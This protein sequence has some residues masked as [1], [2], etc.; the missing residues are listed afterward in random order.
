[1]EHSNVIEQYLRFNGNAPIYVNG[2][3]INAGIMGEHEGY[4][5]VDVGKNDLSYSEKRASKGKA[6]ILVN[7]VTIFDVDLVCSNSPETILINFPKD[8]KLTKSRDRVICGANEREF[9]KEMLSVLSKDAKNI[10]I[11][12]A[13]YPV[14]RELQ[15]NNNDRGDNLEHF[16]INTIKGLVTSSHIRVLPDVPYM[17]QV[18]LQER[19]VLIRPELFRQLKNY[20]PILQEFNGHSGGY[21]VFVAEFMSDDIVFVHDNMVVILNSKYIPHNVEEVAALEMLMGFDDVN[22]QFTGADV[23][24]GSNSKIIGE[25]IGSEKNTSM[26]NN[27]KKWA[28]NFPGIVSFPLVI[29]MKVVEGIGLF[30]SKIPYLD[31]FMPR[32]ANIGPYKGRDYTFFRHMLSSVESRILPNDDMSK[33]PAYVKALEERIKKDVLGKGKKRVD[34]WKD[35]LKRYNIE[36]FDFAKTVENILDLTRKRSESMREG[37]SRVGESGE[38][39]LGSEEYKGMDKLMDDPVFMADV[40][41]LEFINK[42]SM[43]LLAFFSSDKEM[44]NCFDQMV[45]GLRA[46]GMGYGECLALFEGIVKNSSRNQRMNS[47]DVLVRMKGIV[48]CIDRL[49]NVNFADGEEMETFLSKLATRRWLA[50]ITYPKFDRNSHTYL[51]FDAKN[52]SPMTWD[53][54]NFY[55]GNDLDDIDSPSGSYRESLVRGI[56]LLT[57]ILAGDKFDQ[58]YKDKYFDILGKKFLSA[59]R[60]EIAPGELAQFVMYF[61][62]IVSV[63]E[64]KDERFLDVLEKELTKLIRLCKNTIDSD[65]RS[66]YPRVSDIAVKGHSLD[67]VST[68][69]DAGDAKYLFD[70]LQVFSDTVRFKDVD[71]SL[72]LSL[73]KTIMARHIGRSEGFQEWSYTYSSTDKEGEIRI[74]K[75]AQDEYEYI[76]NVLCK[77]TDHGVTSSKDVHR[78]ARPYVF[79]LDSGTDILKKDV[80]PDSARIGGELNTPYSLKLSTLVALYLGGAMKDKN[81]M[82]KDKTAMELLDM[83]RSG[84][85]TAGLITEVSRE[86]AKN[87]IIESINYESSDEYIFIREIIQNVLDA[88]GKELDVSAINGRDWCQLGFTDNVGMSIERVVKFLLIPDSTTKLEDKEARGKFGQGFFT[89][90]K[91]ARMVRVKTSDGTGKLVIV[92]M[93]PVRKGELIVD[94]DI[95]VEIKDDASFKGTN[96]EWLRDSDI[97]QLE[98][99][100]VRSK[101]LTYGCLIDDAE[102]K[103]NWTVNNTTAVINKNKELMGQIET[104]YGKVGLY[105]SGDKENVVTH[106]GLYVR[107]IDKYFWDTIPVHIREQLSDYGIIIDLPAGVELISDRSDV[108]NKEEILSKLQ[109]HLAKLS[110]IAILDLFASNKVKLGFMPYDFMKDGRNWIIPNSVKDDAAALKNGQ[111]INVAPY[112]ASG[113]LFGQLIASIPFISLKGKDEHFSLVYV[114]EGIENGSI[115]LDD[116]VN[117]NIVECITT[118]MKRKAQSRRQAEERREKGYKEFYDITLPIE[119]R[120]DDADVYWAFSEFMKEVSVM[121][122]AGQRENL[123]SA[124][125]M[126]YGS[127]GNDKA[128]AFQNSSAMGWNIYSNMELFDQFSKYL[129]DEI[130]P[131]QAIYTIRDMFSTQLHE[132]AHMLENTGETTHNDEFFARQ[133]ALTKSFLMSIGEISK[134]AE[135][136][137]HEYKGTVIDV[138]SFANYLL[139]YRDKGVSPVTLRDFPAKDIRSPKQMSVLTLT[140]TYAQDHAEELLKLHHLIEGQKWTTDQ[141]LA[142]MWKQGEYGSS[143]DRPF[144][145]KWEHSFVATS[146]DGKPIGVL[147]AY[148]RPANEM[149]GVDGAALY[150]H[151]IAVDP[152]YQGSG[153]GK[154]LMLELAEQLKLRGLQYLTASRGETRIALQTG[155][156]NLAAQKFYFNLGFEEV[157]RKYYPASG[158]GEA[159]S[160]LVLSASCEDVIKNIIGA[161]ASVAVNNMDAFKLTHPWKDFPDQNGRY[162]ADMI[163]DHLSDRVY[164]ARQIQALFPGVAIRPADLVSVSVE[165]GSHRSGSYK[166]YNIVNV[167]AGDKQYRFGILAG[168]LFKNEY[169]EKKLFAD[170]GIGPRVG[171]MGDNEIFKRLNKLE[172]G[173]VAVQHVEG[174]TVSE[175]IDRGDWKEASDIYAEILRKFNTIGFF[176]LDIFNNGDNVIKGNDGNLYIIDHCV[177]EDKTDNLKYP[178]HVLFALMLQANSRGETEV[179]D[180]LDH[181][182]I[183]EIVQMWY[184]DFYMDKPDS[185][186]EDEIDKILLAAGDFSYLAQNPRDVIKTGI[187]G[188]LAESL[189]KT[190]FTDTKGYEAGFAPLKDARFIAGS[191]AMGVV[192]AATSLLSGSL[193]VGIAF[194]IAAAAI[195]VS[196][197]SYFT[198]SESG[199]RSSGNEGMSRR[200][201]LTAA[202]IGIISLSPVIAET[203]N[204][205][206]KQNNAGME[207]PDIVMSDEQIRDLVATLK[208]M[209]FEID[210]EMVRS[211]IRNSNKE[212]NKTMVKE[213][214]EGMRADANIPWNRDDVYPVLFVDGLK[215]EG[216]AM[217]ITDIPLIIV[218]AEN[219]PKDKKQREAWLGEKIAHE[220]T[221]IANRELVELGAMTRL[222]D[223]AAAYRVTAA[224]VEKYEPL[225]KEG[226]ITQRMVSSAFDVI[227]SPSGQAKLKE[228]VNIP[229]DR[230]YYDNIKILG[231]YVGIRI[232]QDAPEGS[233]VKKVVWVDVSEGEIKGIDLD[234]KMELSSAGK[235]LTSVVLAASLLPGSNREQAD[236]ISLNVYKLILKRGLEKHVGALRREGVIDKG[237]LDVFERAL[238]DMFDKDLK[239]KDVVTWHDYTHAANMALRA[240]EAMENVLKENPGMSANALLLT[241][242]AAMYHDVGYYSAD[243]FSGA[244]KFGHEDR[245]MAYVRDHERDLGI[246]SRDAARINLMISATKVEMGS[247]FRDLDPLVNKIS[248]GKASADEIARV[249]TL[250]GQNGFSVDTLGLDLS[251]HRDVEYLL[252]LIYGGEILATLDVYDTRPDVAE[253]IDDLHNEFNF[254]RDTINQKLADEKDSNV[255]A[256]LEML[257]STLEMSKDHLDAIGKTREFYKKYADD[258]VAG[259]GVWGKYIKGEIIDDFDAKRA[260]IYAIGEAAANPDLASSAQYADRHLSRADLEF[261]SRF[262]VMVELERKGMPNFGSLRDIIPRAPPIL[263]LETIIDVFNGIWN[264]YIYANVPSDELAAVGRFKADTIRHSILTAEL[265]GL[266]IR[267]MEKDGQVFSDQDVRDIMIAAIFHDIGK[268]ITAREMASNRIFAKEE[269]PAIVHKHVD[270]LHGNPDKGDYKKFRDVLASYGI[271]I[272]GSSI[273]AIQGMMGEHYV[274]AMPGQNE[275]HRTVEMG[276]LLYMCDDLLGRFDGAREHKKPLEGFSSVVNMAYDRVQKVKTDAELSRDKFYIACT[277]ALSEI[278]PADMMEA[279]DVDKKTFTGLLYEN[280]FLSFRPLVT[281]SSWAGI[282][283]DKVAQA[284][285]KQGLERKIITMYAEHDPSTSKSIIGYKGE[286]YLLEVI[287]EVLEL[288]VFAPDR[289]YVV[290]GLNEEF[291]IPGIRAKDIARSIFALAD[292]SD[293]A[294]KEFV[295]AVAELA[296]LNEIDFVKEFKQKLPKD[297]SDKPYLDLASGPNI[298]YFSNDL[299]ASRKYYFVDRSYYV[300]TFLER[301]MELTGHNNVEI[302]QKDILDL[303]FGDESL[304]T[305][306]VKNLLLYAKVPDTYWDKAAKWITP[307]GQ[308]TVQADPTFK[309]RKDCAEMVRVLYEK[310]VVKDGW[311]FNVILGVEAQQPFDSTLDTVT[312]VKP[313]SGQ[314]LTSNKNLDEYLAS[315]GQKIA[316]KKVEEPAKPI[317]P[318]SREEAYWH[319]SMVSFDKFDENRIGFGTGANQEGWGFSVTPGKENAKEYASGAAGKLQPGQKPISIKI[320]INGQ[321]VNSFAGHEKYYAKRLFNIISA[322]G[323]VEDAREA[324]LSEVREAGD[325]EMEKFIANA[326]ITVNIERYLYRIDV[327]EDPVWLELNGK[328]DKSVWTMI[329]A[330][331]SKE[332]VSFGKYFNIVDGEPQVNMGREIYAALINILGSDKE[333]SLFLDRSGI[334]GNKS[335]HFYT[336]FPS[337]IKM[338][339]RIDMNENIKKGGAIVPEAEAGKGAEKRMTKEELRERV[340]RIQEE[341][342]TVGSFPSVKEAI[343]RVSE[344]IRSVHAKDAKRPVIVVLDGPHIGKSTTAD[345]IMGKNTVLGENFA[346]ETNMDSREIYFIR[347]DYFHEFYASSNTQGYDYLNRLDELPEKEKNRYL[348]LQNLK[349]DKADAQKGK[350]VLKNAMKDYGS[351][352]QYFVNTYLSKILAESGKRVVLWDEAGGEG[353]FTGGAISQGD[354][355]NP[356]AM[357]F[358]TLQQPLG[359]GSV[360]ATV[361][362][363]DWGDVKPISAAPAAE[364]GKGTIPAKTEIITALISKRTGSIVDIMAGVKEDVLDKYSGIHHVPVSELDTIEINVPDGVYHG[365][366]ASSIISAHA[367][368]K[369]TKGKE[370][371]KVLVI[372]TGMGLEAYIAAKNGATVTAVDINKD[373]VKCTR[374]LCDRLGVGERVTCMV[375]DLFSALGNNTYDLIVFNMPH[376]KLGDDNRITKDGDI[377][378]VDVGERLLNVTASEVD[379]YLN[380]QGIAVLVDSEQTRIEKIFAQNPNVNVTH[381]F[382]DVEGPSVAYI[383]TKKDM[384]PAPGIGGYSVDGR[385]MLW[386]V[387]NA[388]HVPWKETVRDVVQEPES[389]TKTLNQKNYLNNQ[390]EVRKMFLDL[391]GRMKSAEKIDFAA[392]LKKLHDV[393]LLGRNGDSPYI[394]ELQTDDDMVIA[395]ETGNV[396]KKRISKLQEYGT[397]YTDWG[398][399]RASTDGPIHNA[400]RE[401]LNLDPEKTS[402]NEMIKCVAE[403]YNAFI[404]KD[405]KDY[406]FQSGNNSL[407]MNM[408]NGMLR[409]WLPEGIAHG[410]RDYDSFK[411]TL[412][413]SLFS[414]V[415]TANK[416][417][418]GETKLAALRRQ[419]PP[420]PGPVSVDSG[421]NKE[422]NDIKEYLNIENKDCP[423][424]DVSKAIKIISGKESYDQVVLELGCGEAI[425]AGFIAKDNRRVGVIATDLYPI[426]ARGSYGD[427]AREWQTGGLDAQNQRLPNLAIVRA[428]AEIF[429]KLPDNSVDYIIFNN[430]ASPVMFDIIRALMNGEIERVLKPG[431]KLFVKPQTMDIVEHYRPGER[432]SGDSEVDGF[433]AELKK[434]VSGDRA[435]FYQL[436]QGGMGGLKIEMRE[437]EEGNFVVFGVDFNEKAEWAEHAVNK[438]VLE[439]TKTAVAAAESDKISAPSA[440]ATK[441]EDVEN[442]NLPSTVHGPETEPQLRGLKEAEIRWSEALEVC[443]NAA[444]EADKAIERMRKTSTAENREKLEL[445]VGELF[446]ARKSFKVVETGFS[447]KVTEFY[448]TGAIN[449]ERYNAYL[450]DIEG[451]KVSNL[452]ALEGRR[453]LLFSDGDYDYYKEQLEVLVVGYDPNRP[454][455]PFVKKVLGVLKKPSAAE[456]ND[457]LQLSIPS[458]IGFKFNGHGMWHSYNFGGAIRDLIDMLRKGI[459]PARAINEMPLS[460]TEGSGSGFGATSPIDSVNG[461]TI[462]SPMGTSL[463]EGGIKYVIMSEFYSEIIP[464]LQREFPNVKFVT[465]L[466]AVEVLREEISKGSVTPAA[467]ADEVSAVVGKTTIYDILGEQD[468][469]L[470]QTLDTPWGTYAGGAGEKLYAGDLAGQMKRDP[471]G[472]VEFTNYIKALTDDLN[473]GVLNIHLLPAFNIEAAAVQVSGGKKAAKEFRK[474]MGVN[475]LLLHFNNGAGTTLRDQLKAAIDE[476]EKTVNKDLCVKIGVNVVGQQQEELEKI[477]TEMQLSDAQRRMIVIESEALPDGATLDNFTMDEVKAVIVGSAILNDNRLCV[478]FGL[479][480]ERLMEN[481]RRMLTA[482]SES[483]IIDIGE[484]INAVNDDAP[485]TIINTEVGQMTANELDAIMREVYKG[486]VTLRINKVNWEE[487]RDYEDSMAAVLK[488]L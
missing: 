461:I 18:R 125:V 21:Q 219:I 343:K 283:N 433:I 424:D 174:E 112:V 36:S 358:V 5:V 26:L 451:T 266:V 320:K 288:D 142:D 229:F 437:E 371:L 319:G 248:S 427:V 62:G 214:Y 264:A 284:R 448:E 477:M 286:K 481:R 443:K 365:V 131:D 290:S 303:D 54:S 90:L 123:G 73:W 60:G 179:L 251:D 466:Q 157:G 313:K 226:I 211:S 418:N 20:R 127:V 80:S 291:R 44:R 217:A 136:I 107:E 7:G 181:E 115:F 234:L 140:K 464:D 483:G 182:K 50:R 391:L 12:N 258:R 474:K 404:Q 187:L 399:G 48:S 355:D 331:A 83:A 221:H 316:V 74:W 370:G 195:S 480:A 275:R 55:S 151:A 246:L 228:L 117:E 158:D 53:L 272:R 459:D 119:G 81:A 402:V 438:N 392:E 141:L 8:A 70:Y 168:V 384:A 180:T 46:V 434:F 178:L 122:I 3:P 361:K 352:L 335:G 93:T 220:G 110:I 169:S 359:S 186:I 51:V 362:T 25:N 22:I 415:V 23:K 64:N 282:A 274:T 265:I 469:V 296:A 297:D 208:G 59:E 66:Q 27:M 428:T 252:A 124:E 218:P 420:A 183:D 400:L 487:L 114:L 212:K 102:L 256:K 449:T 86:T 421:A 257:V 395:D 382:F 334:T 312:F 326:D 63:E 468:K 269:R 205:F 475:T 215:E 71:V 67:I 133:K 327:G 329:Q 462:V 344:I 346:A 106:R 379:K 338:R 121:L 456:F 349:T 351:Y 203:V 43:N 89:V 200:E 354:V 17:G 295:R 6:Y 444:L 225:N 311:S 446:D 479:P 41:A 160:D 189:K 147:I 16:Y 390:L 165:P 236:R 34:L 206:I 30:I 306:R 372:G 317:T 199:V 364:A 431:G 172:V 302:M 152:M 341:I 104:E 267:R 210:A 39:Q 197:I 99:A 273:T 57:E 109:P 146:A 68:F 430:P 366:H 98:T 336:V 360:G 259:F 441:T 435:S 445:A 408:V 77:L 245:S 305:V 322:G 76:V 232:Y 230:M 242:I 91:D 188:Y 485:G 37:K 111:Q 238:N 72:R 162:I 367:T 310:L 11:L 61:S 369:Y 301:M 24:G 318:A 324:L 100:I 314:R 9:I 154:R 118:V 207:M 298:A 126:F 450:K 135:K 350:I 307:G 29:L 401:F 262:S 260:G 425:A 148:E 315:T 170:N 237:L 120:R 452:V 389:K 184:R 193:G 103:I 353:Y 216:F 488:S 467:E 413:D 394:P 253:R 1:M 482:F 101:L 190:A 342:S 376:P 2:K 458:E 194:G 463:N 387:D 113:T 407:G 250:L 386:N 309:G 276:Y 213:I 145:G 470:G 406:I 164:I 422:G 92:Q 65:G 202:G 261:I 138:K 398:R 163:A 271:S 484:A 166:D 132:L 10:D 175:L 377:N 455:D 383:L 345:A 453:A 244:R 417:I 454:V 161:P 460:A 15:R 84:A 304:G 378:V 28:G 95:S 52:S 323:T 426:E 280:A 347:G 96:I 134:I 436:L 19:Y 478:D 375:S 185:E 249:K 97:P 270:I 440:V 144:A 231:N 254:D 88:K 137:K 423:N 278:M 191:L 410:M 337:R 429:S 201:W 285:V 116:I 368:D 243:P 155:D 153:V 32:T 233:K 300:S 105:H 381:D 198:R 49:K 38:H 432:Y 412:K 333:A 222:E 328:P 385:E 177:S 411:D 416:Q 75:T 476:A 380:S 397:E 14:I 472:N 171:D 40:V 176:G 167:T 289:N 348:H 108:T 85:D 56:L 235:G 223:E 47:H 393:L 224:A 447:G 204:S 442:K 139:E 129:R 308:L 4:K 196:S 130:P 13:L 87:S 209:G 159:H 150:V 58:R 409:L 255:R 33:D 356:V 465:A 486:K 78:I 268:Y 156:D 69:T 419:I 330:Q 373:A 45:K 439:W 128:H 192:F 374:D 279:D 240:M 457:M 396:Q 405:T 82:E 227:I 473:R 293:A 287:R 340:N 292:G 79:C 173:M 471:D 281:S 332:G 339:E 247:V 325:A 357:I 241:A 149:Q 35:F 299:G 239:D 42:I 294:A 321:E 143:K 403:F 277:N 94:V 363:W 388:M 414:A 263:S 31:V